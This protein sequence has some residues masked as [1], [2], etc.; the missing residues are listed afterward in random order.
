MVFKKSIIHIALFEMLDEPNKIKTAEGSIHI[1]FLFAGF[2]KYEMSQ[3]GQTR[4]L[5]KLSISLLREK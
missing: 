2:G 3:M 4:Y 5:S 1:S